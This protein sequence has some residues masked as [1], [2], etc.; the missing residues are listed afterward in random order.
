MKT[1]I[2]YSKSADL[3]IPKLNLFNRTVPPLIVGL[4]LAWYDLICQVV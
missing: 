2:S 4:R 1:G 3:R